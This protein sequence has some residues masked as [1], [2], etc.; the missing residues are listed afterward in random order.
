MFKNLNNVSKKLLSGELNREELI[1]L[2][3]H[4]FYIVRLYVAKSKN[5][6]LYIKNLLKKD[7]SKLVREA[8]KNYEPKLLNTLKDLAVKYKNDYIKWSNKNET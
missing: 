8:L 2:S 6:P 1:K 3:K 5:T 4:K 7:K